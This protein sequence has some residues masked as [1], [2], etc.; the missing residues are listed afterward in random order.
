MQRRLHALEQVE[1]RELRSL[2]STLLKERRIEDRER[3]G[4]E[5]PPPEPA[6]TPDQ[7]PEQPIDLKAEFDKA[8][9]EPTLSHVDVF[10]KAA[11]EPIDLTAEFE[12]VSGWSGDGGGEASATRRRTLRPKRRSKSSAVAARGTGRRMLS[13]Q[14]GRPDPNRDENTEGPPS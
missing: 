12:R 13:G 10:N 11:K 6:P 5:P 8:S 4:R 7:T 2:E 9:A 3:T 1:K 14:R